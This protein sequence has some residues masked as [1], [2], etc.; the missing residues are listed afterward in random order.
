MTLSRHIATLVLPTLL[1]LLGLA[2]PAAAQD[3]E[4]YEQPDFAGLRLTLSQAVPDLSGYGLQ[5]RVSSVIVHRGQWEFCT[6]AQWRGDCVTAGPGR[7]ARLPPALNDSVVSLRPAGAGV[8]GPPRPRPEAPRQPT[9]VLYAGDFSGPELRLSE[10]VDDLRRRAFN[11]SATTVEVLAGQWELCSDGGYGGHCLRLGPGRHALPPP[12]RDRL[13]SLRPWTG[14]GT[15][16][17]PGGSGV[18]GGP[19]RPWAGAAPAL[20]LYEHAGGGG[21][22]LELH[23]ASANLGA[24]GFNDRASSVE[25]LRGRWQLC[26]HADFQGEC[27]VLGPGRHTLEGRLH[28]GVSSLRPLWGRDARPQAPAAALT[29]HD[30]IDLRGRALY[31]DALVDNLRDLDFNDRAVAVEVHGGRWELCSASH[32]RGRCAEFGPGWH[33]LPEGLA[34]ELSSLRPR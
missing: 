16:G 14:P 32:G 26:R 7:Y 27:V 19:G 5:R 33:R 24:Q 28:D 4:L 31:V 10:A 34:R 15:T 29:L 1:T 20:V 2:T 23:E 22:A 8:G 21:R 9:V 17:T 30:Q 12:L 11:D 13:S 3:V 18:H 6:Q 25:V